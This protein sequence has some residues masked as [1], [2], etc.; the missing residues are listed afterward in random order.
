MNNHKTL[1]ALLAEQARLQAEIHTLQLHHRQQALDEIKTLMT[2]Y[3]ITVA[4]LDG[5]PV[6]AARTVRR[7]VPAK[8]RDPVSGHTW[9]GRG[10][11]PTWIRGKD[12]DAFKI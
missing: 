4:D 3:G 1:E 2:K 10:R 5:V 6:P 12:R 9:S 7:M 11:S 8:Y